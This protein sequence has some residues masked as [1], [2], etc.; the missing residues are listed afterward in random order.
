ML[1]AGGHRRTRQVQRALDIYGLIKL[2]RM[3]DIFPEEVV[4]IAQRVLAQVSAR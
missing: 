1:H 4:E 2:D 3:R